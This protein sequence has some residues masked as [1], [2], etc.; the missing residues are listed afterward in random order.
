MTV[1]AATATRS[2]AVS[3][4]PSEVGPDENQ[5]DLIGENFSRKRSSAERWPYQ[6]SRENIT[7]QESLRDARFTETVNEMFHGIRNSQWVM[8]IMLAD[9]IDGKIGSAFEKIL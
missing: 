4:V 8:K 7:F 9:K 2:T 1:L 5:N 3:D 6:K